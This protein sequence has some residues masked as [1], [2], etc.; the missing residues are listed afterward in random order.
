[1]E[2]DII[3]KI[4]ESGLRGRGGGNFEAWL[5]WDIASKQNGRKYVIC[6]GAD[7]EIESSKDGYIMDNYLDDVVFGI[8]SAVDFLNAE[9]AYFYLRSDYF[10]KYKERLSKIIDKDKIEIFKKP[11]VGYIGG[12][13]TVICEVIEGGGAFP[14]SKP[15]FLTK[16]GLYGMPTLINNV[17]TFYCIS[18]ILKGEYKNKRFFSVIGNATKKGVYELPCDLTIEDVLRKTGNYPDFKFFVRIGGKFGSF[19]FPKELSINFSGLGVIEIFDQERVDNFELVQEM[20]EFFHKGNCD[21]C[22][23]CREGFFEIY[24]M[25]RKKEFDREKINGILFSLENSSFCYFGKGAANSLNS[26]LKKIMK[27]G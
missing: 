25:A 13:E 18:K 10:E 27:N 16:D 5:K 9:K 7:G 23:P 1:M 24:E 6:N 2:K 26:F 21:K 3:E 17:E 11:D 12:E 8:K 14:R 22:T 15:P 19:Y 4:R 20:A